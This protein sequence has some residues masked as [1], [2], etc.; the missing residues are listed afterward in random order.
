[1]RNGDLLLWVLLAA[2]VAL[3]VLVLT[4]CA[5]PRPPTP[6]LACQLREAPPPWYRVDV[7]ADDRCPSE[8]IC[9]TRSGGQAIL[10][11]HQLASWSEEAWLRCGILEGRTAPVPSHPP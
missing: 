11:N 3:A 6:S 2:S 1:M 9:L 4:S 7:A 10:L 5:C 8:Y